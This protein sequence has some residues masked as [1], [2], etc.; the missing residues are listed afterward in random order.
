MS[1]TSIISLGLFKTRECLHYFVNQS[2]NYDDDDGK[3]SDFPNLHHFLTDILNIWIF[4][5]DALFIAAINSVT[6]HNNILCSTRISEIKTG[7][8]CKQH[9]FWLKVVATAMSTCVCIA[10]GNC[11]YVLLVL[12]GM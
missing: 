4:K 6:F 11:E 12:G 2:G 9:S 3:Y 10:L 8:E 1:I 7:P 5:I